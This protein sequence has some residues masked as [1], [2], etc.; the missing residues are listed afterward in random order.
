MY[1][2]SLQWQMLRAVACCHAHGLVHR[3][4]KE[5]NFAYDCSSEFATLKLCVRQSQLASLAQP[6]GLTFDAGRLD[7]GLTLG[8]RSGLPLNGEQDILQVSTCNMHLC[9]YTSV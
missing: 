3:D 8:T 6:C 5:D 1:M 9:A 4:L 2:K 7:F